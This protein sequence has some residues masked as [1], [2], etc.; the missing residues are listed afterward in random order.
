MTKL[1]LTIALFSTLNLMA[2]PFKLIEETK[3]QVSH[4]VSQKFIYAQNAA[5]QWNATAQFDLGLMYARGKGVAQDT[6]QAFNWLHK[7]A[8]N[9][10]VEA[11]FYMGINFAQGIG[12]RQQ[13]ELARYWFKLAAKAGHPKAVAHLASIEKHLERHYN[14]NS[15]IA[16]NK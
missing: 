4:T 13:P 9:D 3:T 2:N 16:F 5:K 12:V 15:R 10:H 14:E 11:K 6:R 8:R 1:I 7:A